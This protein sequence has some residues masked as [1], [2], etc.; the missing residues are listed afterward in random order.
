MGN[1]A[2]LMN[3]KPRSARRIVLLLLSPLLVVLAGLSISVGVAAFNGFEL[4]AE[5]MAALQ[6]QP[7]EVF[8]LTELL[9]RCLI[10]PFQLIFIGLVFAAATFVYRRRAQLAEWVL[11]YKVTQRIAEGFP[12]DASYNLAGMNEL[13]LS[14]VRPGRRRAVHQIVAS[15]IGIAALATAFVISLGQF[16]ALTALAVVA[17]A[18]TSSLAWGGRLIVGDFL[19]GIGNIFENNYNVGDDVQLRLIDKQ[20][21]EGDVEAVNLRY[22]SLRALTGELLTVPH[23]DIRIFRNY[24]RRSE[25]G[26]Y[27]TVPVASSDLP[28]AVAVLNQLATESPALIPHLLEPLQIVCQDGRLAESVELSLY[29]RKHAGDTRSLQLAIA[30]EVRERFAAAGIGGHPADA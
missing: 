10:L 5:T 30:T 3:D 24:S 13:G 18:L 11:G 2:T 19:G 7:Q 8:Q 17:T 29:G 22:A 28:A 4:G 26:V 14:Q 1:P 25:L 23:G 9:A 27:V 16:V 12:E 15:V 6:G 20:Q 21:V